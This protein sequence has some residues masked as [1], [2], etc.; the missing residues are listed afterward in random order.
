[1]SELKSVDIAPPGLMST[2]MS[3]ATA[4]YMNPTDTVIP[5][6]PVAPLSS[7]ARTVIG[8]MP[9]TLGLP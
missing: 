8:K 1:M 6:D 9:E 2:R 7:T 4:E 3:G 5:R